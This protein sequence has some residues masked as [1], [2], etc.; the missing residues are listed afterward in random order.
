MRGSPQNV[1]IKRR[2]E[3]FSKILEVGGTHVDIETKRYI[4]TED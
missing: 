3:T 4:S 2:E 1:L